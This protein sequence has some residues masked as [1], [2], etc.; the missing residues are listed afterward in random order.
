M[1]ILHII[2][3]RPECTGSGIYLQAIMKQAAL[4]G[5]T[6]HLVAGIPDATTPDPDIID[7]N[8]CTF[9]RFETDKLPFPVT[10]MSDVMP[11]ESSRFSEMT[12]R[13]AQETYLETCREEDGTRG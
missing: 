2:S 4:K 10:G 12:V 11:Y 6:N 8:L 5:Y 13:R 7:H 3:Q 1:K 9:V